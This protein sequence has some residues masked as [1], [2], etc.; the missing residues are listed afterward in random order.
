MRKKRRRQ[1]ERKSNSKQRHPEASETPSSSNFLFKS[2][3][4]ELVTAQNQKQ[5]QNQLIKVV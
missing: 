2:C 1:K 5:N 4:S 3:R